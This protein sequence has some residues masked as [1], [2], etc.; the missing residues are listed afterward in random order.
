[1]LLQ[2]YL[3]NGVEPSTYLRT[4][5]SQ[6]RV[7]GT[8]RLAASLQAFGLVRNKHSHIRMYARVVVQANPFTTDVHQQLV[9]L[10]AV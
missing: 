4:L 10:S 9:L 2:Y 5:R 7:L 3:V 6:R 1:M 8:A